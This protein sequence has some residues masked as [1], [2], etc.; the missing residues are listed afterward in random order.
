MNARGFFGISDTVNKGY[1]RIR[2]N[3]QVKSEAGV[4]TLTAL[5]MHSPVYEMVSRAVPVEFSLTKI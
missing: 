3:M 2:V 4:E 5:A 1:E